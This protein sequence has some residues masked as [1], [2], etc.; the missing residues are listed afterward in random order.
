MIHP[1]FFI[2]I[3]PDETLQEEV[4]TFK[5]YCARHFGASHALKS[6]PHLTLVPPFRRA[7]T[8][9]PALCAALGDFAASQEPFEVELHNFGCFAPRVLFVDLTPNPKL[10]ELA[11]GL[12][13]HLEEHTGLKQRNEHGFNPHMTIAHRDLERK[14]FPAAWAHFSQLEFRRR[15]R[16]EALALLRHRDGRWVIER[17]FEF[18]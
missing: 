10:A 15:F 6:P 14:V 5:R 7:E 8:G 2:A 4:T 16:A 11:A 13:A 3:L 12:A 17:E 18:S 1:L 9:L